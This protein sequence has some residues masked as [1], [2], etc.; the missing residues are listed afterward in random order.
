MR[1]IDADPIVETLKE[2]RKKADSPRRDLDLLILQEMIQLAPTITPP[3]NDLLTLEELREMDG[4]QRA[5]EPWK[6]FL[7]TR[8]E[9]KE[10]PV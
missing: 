9:R 3:P 1:L 7:M 8:F 2:A 6:D 10:G 4:E 5:T